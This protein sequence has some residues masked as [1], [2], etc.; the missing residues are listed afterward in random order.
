MRFR[1]PG[2]AGSILR[3]RLCVLLVSG[4][5]GS[6]VALRAVADAT[7]AA[8]TPVRGGAALLVQAEEAPQT[9][10][11]IVREPAPLDDIA[12]I[13]TLEVESALR[14]DAAAGDRI[15]F[16][17]EERLPSRPPRFDPGRRVLLALEPLPAWSIWRERLG[18]RSALGVAGRGEGFLLD[19]DEPTVTA[20]AAYLALEPEA[21]ANAAG[22][23]A[24]LV[25][26]SDAQ[27][28]LRSAALE[29][30]D[31]VPDVD[32]SLDDAGAALWAKLV[33][34]PDVPATLRSRAAALAGRHHITRLAPA[35][36]Q[37]SQPGSDI[38][39]A[40]VDALGETLGGLPAAEVAELLS[41]ADPAVRAMAI[42][43]ARSDLEPDPAVAAL[44]G[45]DSPLVRVEAVRGLAGRRGVDALPL[46]LGALDDGD[47]RVRGAAAR[48][49]GSLGEPAVPALAARVRETDLDGAREA[50]IALARAGDA[51]RLAL[52]GVAGEHPSDRV[53]EFARFLLGRPS[54]PH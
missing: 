31:R 32:R 40:A 46:L 50:M 47:A 36:R 29:R 4:L 10:V 17:W 48:S 2:A 37:A 16:A 44:A 18:D 6:A 12:W 23:R 39:P 26:A 5:L 24:L 20:L 49:L 53:R 15:P 19:P 38:A 28:P 35:L 22:V 11:G 1:I 25:L 45:D 13:A 9:V 42:R 51:G 21:R 52:A 27:A 41:R 7:P 14:G 33:T 54:A 8:P 43:R 3:A 30:L 34:G